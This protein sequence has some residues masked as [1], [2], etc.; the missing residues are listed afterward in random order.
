MKEKDEKI[1]AYRIG[2]GL[3]CPDCYEKTVRDLKAVQDPEEP[4]VTVPA[5]AI[6]EGD[7]RIYICEQCE[8]IKG[9][10]KVLSVEKQRELETLREQRI[11]QMRLA[12]LGVPDK[13]EKTKP[14]ERRARRQ[15]AF[16]DLE[17]MMDDIFFKVHFI[18]DF[19]SHRVPDDEIFSDSGRSGFYHILFDLEEDIKFV[20]DGMSMIK[21]KKNHKDP[22]SAN[23]VN[24]ADGLLETIEAARST[25]K[26]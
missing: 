21:N 11:L 22:D 14:I 26:I 16:V 7:I 10:P 18:Q 17:D 5:K 2:Q 20:Q 13:L 24:L 9:D 8:A 25:G 19:F 15:D 1:I 4:Q 3:F 6:K 12:V 23:A